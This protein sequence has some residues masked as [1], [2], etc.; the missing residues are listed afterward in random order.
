MPA[1]SLKGLLSSLSHIG[2]IYLKTNP[3]FHKAG[4]QLSFLLL[5]LEVFLGFGWLRSPVWPRLWELSYTAPGSG[6]AGA[7][8]MC[9]L[10]D[11][12]P[13]WRFGGGSSISEQWKEARRLSLSAACSACTPG[14]REGLAL[15]SLVHN[16]PPA[17]TELL[18]SAFS[19]PKKVTGLNMA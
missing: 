8:P 10:E 7:L 15:C 11:V 5:L 1:G 3:L 4:W 6:S 19:P 13:P 17:C 16:N 14:R 2:F 18:P 9:L 12:A